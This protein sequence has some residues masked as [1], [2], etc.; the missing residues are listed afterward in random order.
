MRNLLLKPIYSGNRTNCANLISEVVMLRRKGILTDEEFNALIR[1]VES[2]YIETEVT[3]QVNE[4]IEN[5]I[6]P[7]FNLDGCYAE[8]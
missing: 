4:T 3:N 7:Y 2:D 6:Y 8:R 1:I 5:K